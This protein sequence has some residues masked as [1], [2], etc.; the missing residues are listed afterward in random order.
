MDLWLH[1]RGSERGARENKAP[2]RQ[3]QG[4]PGVLTRRTLSLKTVSNSVEIDCPATESLSE[5][6]F[7]VF[8][9]KRSSTLQPVPLKV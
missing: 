7:A 6:S 3:T 8:D 4:R 9:Q 2:H 5:T 1:G